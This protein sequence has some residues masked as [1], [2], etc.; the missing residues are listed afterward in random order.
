MFV[1][2]GYRLPQA[3]N[4]IFSDSHKFNKA[5]YRLAN[6]HYG[7][8]SHSSSIKTGQSLYK[9]G[10]MVSLNLLLAPLNLPF[11]NS[12]AHSKKQCFIIPSAHRFS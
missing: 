6:Y 12:V 11:E 3:T 9:G 8:S 4:P 5:E 10:L 2:D 7:L 1:S